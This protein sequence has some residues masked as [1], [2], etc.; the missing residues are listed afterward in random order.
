LWQ[1]LDESE[2][3]EEG[4]EDKECGSASCKD[5]YHSGYDQYK[6]VE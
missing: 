1:R 6:D 4:R 5:D 3:E 2:D